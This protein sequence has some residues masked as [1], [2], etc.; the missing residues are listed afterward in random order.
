MHDADSNDPFDLFVSTTNVRYCYYRETPRILGTTF[1]MAVL[2]DFEGITPNALCRAVET[3]SG[4][5]I[6]VLLLHSM[7][8]LKQLYTM[9]VRMG[10]GG[11]VTGGAA[12][13]R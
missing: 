11:V 9:A 7:T 6:V 10:G 12:P 2:Q 5:G 1:G 4:G 8:S 3:V 13:G